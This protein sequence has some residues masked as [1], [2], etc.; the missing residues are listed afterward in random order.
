MEEDIEILS[1]ALSE[2]LESEPRWTEH[3]LIERL[4]QPPYQ[5]FEAEALRDPLSLFQTHFIVF[6]CLYRL[7]RQWR[8]AQHAELSIHTLAVERG[9]WQAGEEGLAEADPLADYY[10]DLNQ[11]AETST[12]DVNRLLD[13]FWDKMGA[14]PAAVAPSLSL[15]KAC[16]I[17]AVELPLNAT[18]L[19]RQY[20]RLV[21]QHHPDKGGS[22]AMM[23]QVKKAY[24]RLSLEV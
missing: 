18:E 24:Q 12:D 17:M 13:D 2:L 8:A 14:S 6:H 1:A 3:Q 16:E 23:Q 20:R 7:Q 15:D 21:H 9:A 5:L 11:L 4:Q 22:V 19:K 10:L